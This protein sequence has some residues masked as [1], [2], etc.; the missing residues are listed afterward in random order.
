MRWLPLLAALMASP[1]FAYGPSGPI[2]NNGDGLHLRILVSDAFNCD[3]AGTCGP[4]NATS[5]LTSLYIPG[6]HGW[7]KTAT[8]TGS[9]PCIDQAGTICPTETQA[10]LPGGI[11]SRIVGARLHPHIEQGLLAWV[12]DYIEVLGTW[13]ITVVDVEEELGDGACHAN[14]AGGTIW[15]AK[16][17]VRWGPPL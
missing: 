4:T 15:R 2:P 8:T 1:A 10:C 3:A 12:S 9:A 11:A 13:T 14:D 7:D 5:T 6:A 17:T 16:V